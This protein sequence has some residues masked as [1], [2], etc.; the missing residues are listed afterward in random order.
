MNKVHVAVI[1]HMH[2]LQHFREGED[3]HDLSKAV[4][5]DSTL[6]LDLQGRVDQL[7]VET[8]ETKRLHRINI[9]HLRRMNTDLKFMRTEIT[10]LEELIRQ[11]MMKKF[12]MVIDLDELEEEVLRKYVFELETTAEDELHLLEIEM[13]KKRVSRLCVAGPYLKCVIQ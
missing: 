4:L 13:K 6:L 1:L 11:E 7:K 2:Q 8:L 5:F 10:R 3:Y 12:G 9:V